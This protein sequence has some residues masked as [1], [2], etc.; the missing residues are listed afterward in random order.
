L[1]TK[2]HNPLAFVWDA[3]KGAAEFP[4]AFKKGEV[5]MGMVSIT[6][7]CGC[8]G[9]HKIVCNQP[10]NRD[11][12]AIRRKQ[13]G[14]CPDCYREKLVADFRERWGR[15]PSVNATSE[16]Q[17]AF[18]VR[19]LMTL[20]GS[21]RVRSGLVEMLMSTPHLPVRDLLDCYMAE[22]RAD[23]PAWTGMISWQ[24]LVLRS[25][26]PDLWAKFIS[27]CPPSNTA[28]Q[29]ELDRRQV[30]LE[31]LGRRLNAAHEEKTENRPHEEVPPESL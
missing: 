29:M 14:L 23:S 11:K 18:A 12:E 5:A 21:G 16:K 19:V 20:L 2:R 13:L 3:F 28:Q 15:L 22:C 4:A 25:A 8:P 24:E 6:Y 27:A 9:E 1:R 7:Q 31:R 10:T 26:Y 17:E 30:R